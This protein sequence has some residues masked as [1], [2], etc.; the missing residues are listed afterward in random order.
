[1]AQQN[2]KPDYSKLDSKL[3]K[4]NQKYN[5]YPTFSG[6]P[7]EYNT[8]ASR[9]YDAGL[10]KE[11]VV[12]ELGVL[13]SK[14]NKSDY[15][16][17]SSEDFTTGDDNISVARGSGKNKDGTTRIKNESI[18]E[19]ANTANRRVKN[20]MNQ[21]ITTDTDGN[22]EYHRFDTNKREAGIQSGDGFDLHHKRTL[23]QF[24]PFYEGLSDDEAIE[25]TNWFD[26][27]GYTVGNNEKNLLKMTEA[28][29]MGQ[30]SIHEWM[31]D[32]RLNPKTNMDEYRQLSNHFKDRPLNDRFA[33]I[34]R[35]LNDT[36]EQV[37]ARLGTRGGYT[38]LNEIRDSVGTIPSGPRAGQ[39][40]PVNR[41]TLGNAII[42]DIVNTG[43]S[44]K[45]NP[46]GRQVGKGLAKLGMAV[47]LV[48]LGIGFG[49]AGH[50]ASQG[51][52]AGAAAHTAGALIG[53]VPIV[54]DVIVDSVAG[55]GLADGTLQSN[56]NRVNQT[57]YQEPKN[58]AAPTG[59]T[60]F[61]DVAQP[62]I[63][64][65]AGQ[66]MNLNPNGGSIKYGF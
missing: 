65:L 39:R 41:V 50:A 63:K 18:Y 5:N 54:G 10:S 49:Q 7:T 32:R 60:A 40:M 35:Y 6:T 47:P 13:R 27:E 55:T 44:A 36:Q 57:L 43:G 4:P 53:E 64:G 42:D 58:T 34:V 3:K 20:E 29:H 30:G 19:G 26:Q 33:D 12:S 52:Y 16:H 61:D 48:G 1:M 66:P 31:D 28:E 24:A 62:L 14:L 37:E 9:M 51:D 2:N 15:P 25:L 59:I 21:S 22:Y 46:N 38:G 11:E 8:L 45:F 56:Q 17:V 23:N